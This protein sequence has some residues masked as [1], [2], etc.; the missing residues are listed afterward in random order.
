MTEQVLGLVFT[1]S[2]KIILDNVPLSRAC[3]SDFAAKFCI[4][5][6]FYS[7]FGLGLTLWNSISELCIRCKLF[8]FEYLVFTKIKPGYEMGPG[9][10]FCS[11]TR[12]LISN[13][14]K[15]ALSAEKLHNERVN[16]KML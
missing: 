3:S 7:L 14:S 12:D 6:L 11:L 4:K 10:Q 5:I 16:T 8:G 15:I 9:N 1:V 2:L 13:E